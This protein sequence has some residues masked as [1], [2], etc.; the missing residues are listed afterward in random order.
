MLQTAL[1]GGAFAFF[2]QE[3]F[4]SVTAEHA[5]FVSIY[6]FR[7]FHCCRV[8]VWQRAADTEGCFVDLTDI[9]YVD[10]HEDK[11]GCCQ[12]CSSKL[13]SDVV[14]DYCI[15]TTTLTGC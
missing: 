4:G 6:L 14:C 9:Q 8:C 13:E 5:V 11:S 1:H 7:V 10:K 3:I 12:R 15:E 2:P